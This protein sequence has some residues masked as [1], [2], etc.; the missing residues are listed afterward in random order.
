M[1]LILPN[2]RPLAMSYTDSQAET[3]HMRFIGNADLRS[4]G[5]VRRALEAGRLNAEGVA[6]FARDFADELVSLLQ[7]TGIPDEKLY[8]TFHPNMFTQAYAQ[9]MTTATEQ[10]L[11]DMAREEGEGDPMDLVHENTEDGIKLKDTPITLAEI[12]EALGD[13]GI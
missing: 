3:S 2:G 9:I 4:F 13:M 5:S 6:E 11:L 7:D 12:T 1:A 8:M 10:E